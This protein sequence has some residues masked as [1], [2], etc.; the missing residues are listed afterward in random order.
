[1]MDFLDS[2]YPLPAGLREELKGLV[3]FRKL[4]KGEY[5]LRA[6]EV[7]RHIYFVGKGLLRCY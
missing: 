5:L 7:C 6:G 1:M 2:I 4:E 3:K